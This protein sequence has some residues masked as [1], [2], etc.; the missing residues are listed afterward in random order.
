MSSSSHGTLARW[1]LS[2]SRH[3]DAGLS[4]VQGIRTIEGPP[5]RDRERLA[6]NLASGNGLDSVLGAAPSWLSETDRQ[7]ISAGHGSG[8]LPE[9]LR[10]LAGQHQSKQ[11]AIRAVIGAC[12]YPLFVLHFAVLVLPAGQLMTGSPVD[13]FRSVFNLLVPLWAVIT[14][15]VIGVRARIR[16]LEGLG[17]WLPGI[18][19]Y[20]R[21]GAFRDICLVLRAFLS[22]GCRLDEAWYGACAATGRRRYIAAGVRCAATVQAGSPPSSVL[23]ELGLF[24]PEFVEVYRTGEETGKLE[25][26]LR[27]LQDEYEHKAAGSLASA[28]FWYPKLLFLIVALFMAW[29]VLQFYAGYFQSIEEMME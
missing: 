7:L 2:L 11:R 12:V 22:A 16:I 27:Y 21:Y 24:P 20:R 28:A 26:S 15:L 6:D 17:D 29:Q 18:R 14:L 10:Q 4:L 3:L 25:E 23:G 1:Y 5:R 9:I 19:G 13:Y 8:N